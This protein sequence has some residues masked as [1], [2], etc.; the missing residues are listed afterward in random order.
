[1]KKQFPL[2][3]WLLVTA[4]SLKAQITITELSPGA[5]NLNVA[6]TACQ[7]NHITLQINKTT[8]N[9]I[10]GETANLTVG[11]SSFLSPEATWTVS[12]G[13]S[14][15][16][17]FTNPLLPTAVISGFSANTNF[18]TIDLF[19]SGTCF[20]PSPNPLSSWPVNRP[21][22]QVM[23]TSSGT[24]S[25]PS[26]GIY[27]MNRPVIVLD[28]GA[29]TNLSFSNAQAGVPYTRT[30]VYRNSSVYV[31]SGEIEFADLT[32]SVT[33]S[34]LISFQTINSTSPSL[35]N[36]VVSTVP[37]LSRN[38]AYLTATVTG[39][40]P[41]ASFTITET[42]LINACTVNQIDG[43]STADF[44]YGCTASNR[45]WAAPSV[46]PLG[47]LQSGNLALRYENMIHF[48]INQYQCPGDPDHRKIKLT[49]T[50]T[51][52][53]TGVSFRYGRNTGSLSYLDIPSINMYYIDP[54]TLL[55]VPLTPTSISS[56]PSNGTPAC[57]SGA[58]YDLYL[59]SQPLEYFFQTPNGFTL[60]PNESVYIEYDEK[61]DWICGTL[62]LCPANE[63]FNRPYLMND[64]VLEA[65]LL[66][67]CISLQV[68]RSFDNI[69]T[70]GQGAPRQIFSLT[71]NYATNVNTMTL[72]QE[73]V[74]DI[75]N[76]TPLRMEMFANPAV[77]E[78]VFDPAKMQIVVI[79]EIE[80]GLDLV[81][82][83]LNN[84]QM[85]SSNEQICLHSL[86]NSGPEIIYPSSSILNLGSFP[87]QGGVIRKYEA[88]FDIPA[89]MYASVNPSTPGLRFDAGAYWEKTL[90]WDQFF[91]NF[92][93]K[94]TVKTNCRDLPLDSRSDMIQD[95]YLDYDNTCSNSCLIPLSHVMKS[96]YINCPGCILP[97]WNLSGMVLERTTL[98]VQDDNDNHY[99]DDPIN[100]PTATRSLIAR[101]HVM[102]GD[103]FDCNINAL[104]SDGDNGLSV[105]N[106]PGST[107]LQFGT[108][109]PGVIGFTL[110]NLQLHMQSLFFPQLCVQSIVCTFTSTTNGVVT[111]AIPG[112]VYAINGTVLDVNMRIQDM[113][114]WS[115]NA[116][117]I[118][119]FGNGQFIQFVVHFKVIGNNPTGP[120]IEAH[121]INAYI[122]M[123]ADPINNSMPDA[124]DHQ[125]LIGNPTTPATVRDDYLYWCTGW[126][127]TIVQGKVNYE[128]K[129]ELKHFAGYPIS[130]PKLFCERMLEVRSI[131]TVGGQNIQANGF[132]KDLN[133]SDQAALNFF[134]FEY[135]EL[136]TPTQV[137]VQIPPGYTVDEIRI[138][139]ANPSY[140][141]ISNIVIYAPSC[142]TDAND[143]TPN[144]YYT[145]PFTPSMISGGLL[146]FN[147]TNPVNYSYSNSEP[148]DCSTL[149]LGD[150][151]RRIFIQIVLKMD[152]CTLT[153]PVQNIGGYTATLQL[154]KMPETQIGQCSTVPSSTIRTSVMLSN[155]NLHK[156]QA[157]FNTNVTPSVTN[158]GAN[159]AN[160]LCWNLNMSVIPLITSIDGGGDI[161]YA[162]QYAQYPFIYV[163]SPTGNITGFTINQSWTSIPVPNGVIYLIT[164][165]LTTSVAAAQICAFYTCATGNPQTENLIFTFGWNCDQPVASLVD[166]ANACYTTQNTV[167]IIPQPSNITA[168]MSVSQTINPCGTIHVTVNVNA[169]GPEDI[170][171]TTTCFTNIP[172]ILDYISGSATVV[173]NNNPS[174]SIIGTTTNNQTCF[175]LGAVGAINGSGSNNGYILE[176]D[177]QAGCPFGP[178]QPITIT[179]DADNYCGANLGPIN[180]T[181]NVQSINGLVFESYTGNATTQTLSCSVSQTLTLVL[182]YTGTTVSGQNGNS[183]TATITLPNGLQYLPG[184]TTPTSTNNNVNTY[185]IPSG[186][187]PN[188]TYTITIVV[189][190]VTPSCTQWQIPYTVSSS[191]VN[192]CLNTSCVITNT[193]TAGNMQLDETYPYIGG[194]IAN[195]IPICYPGTGPVLVNVSNAATVPSLNT[196]VVIYCD[197]GNIGQCIFA[198]GTAN[199]PANGNVT[200]SLP[201][202]GNPCPTCTGPYTLVIGG[203]PGECICQPYIEQL[204]L[205]CTTQCSFT[206]SQ[207]NVTCIGGN[208]GSITISPAIGIPPF[209]YI[210]TPNV[211]TTNAV[212]NL[213]A[214]T[215]TCQI[216][217]NA[218][219]SVTLTFTI[220]QPSFPAITINP[221]L[222]PFCIQTAGY[223]LTAYATPQGG[224]W[225]G[226]GVN[227]D[228]FNSNLVGVG[229]YNLT[230]T[231]TDPSGCTSVATMPVSVLPGN[232]P[233]N[234]PKHI[235]VG[236]NAAL[237]TV[238]DGQGNVYV[239]GYFYGTCFFP[240]FGNL[241]ALGNTSDIFVAK[242]NDQCGT[243]WVKQFSGT[244][245]DRG[246]GI[247]LSASGEV[248]VT[249]YFEGALTVQSL[250]TF[251]TPVNSREAFVLRLD[252]NGTALNF[253]MSNSSNGPANPE[254]VAITVNL[255]TSEVYVIGNYKYVTGFSG[256]LPNAGN[257]SEVFIVRYNASLSLALDQI[258]IGSNAGFSGQKRNDYAGGIGLDNA[259][260]VYAGITIEGG[261]F[262]FGVSLLNFPNTGGIADIFIPMFN[263]SLI[264]QTAQKFG[265]NSHDCIVTDLTTDASGNCFI[266]G[267]FEG[268][269]TIGNALSSNVNSRDVFFARVDPLTTASWLRTG[270]AVGPAIESGEGVAIDN[271]SGK[272]WFTGTA[273]QG[274]SFTGFTPPGIVGSNPGSNEIFVCSFSSTSGIPQTIENSNSSLSNNFNSGFGITIGIVQNAYVAG[275]IGNNNN[276]IVTFN[277]TPLQVDGSGNGVL[278]RAKSSTGDFYRV[279]DQDTTISENGLSVYPNPTTGALTIYLEN[280]ITT[281]CQIIVTDA[282]GNQILGFS[283][284]RTSDYTMYLDLSTVANGIYL[285]QVVQ[286][287]QVSTERIVIAR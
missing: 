17:D 131:M 79:L 198:S 54:N 46:S 227:G 8:G 257:R 41:N 154:D 23:M 12:S 141:G 244:K 21:S 66:H 249:G 111:F 155:T 160:Q 39:L 275:Q 242:Y 182:T 266:T 116:I 148:S 74:F 190:S 196:S 69:Q 97:G 175:N 195:Q 168:S 13:L 250:G 283:A 43:E 136:A 61:K 210:W 229:T 166:V 29:S 82:F 223:D 129:Y 20:V 34:T 145:Y 202:S 233:R 259:G 204:T 76:V 37:Y 121:D 230:Y 201:V 75:Q 151:N 226:P 153:P 28:A 178:S 199:V 3:V 170:N 287:G 277:S 282:L 191:I 73:Q 163:S 24:A 269:L 64:F 255:T 262:N 27:T 44:N 159:N 216:T 1:M 90:D 235:T 18:F 247:A 104:I 271:A 209:V 134:P 221:P 217:D 102:V 67:P 53:S 92:Q 9:F 95:L 81:N 84:P 94:Y 265:N 222:T 14:V 126:S 211:G 174:Q 281:D 260:N 115:N 57:S 105:P 85:L 123:A 52:T 146:S 149:F 272:V 284:S 241:T 19:V 237:A 142:N 240:G 273:I 31:F 36:I 234:W 32:S 127:S 278:A 213:T 173:Y 200:I 218:G 140:A 169:S 252:Q 62:P 258:N 286:N 147:L 215:Y 114:A 117:T 60:A 181:G 51:V 276:N 270:G 10:S 86:Q 98:G 119:E 231:Y 87:Y 162:Y 80:Q 91:N 285:I 113:A 118:T 133:F 238:A 279:A 6:A 205:N 179:V 167:T 264:G 71:Q 251:N 197:Y 144:D 253:A 11:L 35:S 143:F 161:D 96:V 16:T 72:N 40:A 89:Y 220:T 228:F 274:A 59:T 25:L 120:D 4:I 2:L 58:G 225:S 164:N 150:E 267:S 165:G 110:D 5:S 22:Y 63:E 214:G 139:F 243:V 33:S 268:S 203:S 107:G 188:G 263:A 78:L 50:G 245:D 239:T 112:S 138:K 193:V 232:A 177:V 99:P 38:R 280:G 45:C 254:G 246:T 101:D 256:S 206:S 186:I 83:P 103:E 108:T 224:I 93:V 261:V 77:N 157:V 207:T 156:P 106:C 132:R 189:G 135:R 137:D 26:Q 187:Q 122:Y 180:L 70:N 208:N 42:I 15:S 55:Q 7:P 48:P 183:S 125:C 65:T 185:L 236:R 194:V 184:G 248:Y 172:G 158:V 56:L 128:Q 68:A 109:G 176:F 100:L 171:N 212:S 152:D 192:T 88:R 124:N 30:F 130:G 49:N 219:C 47:T